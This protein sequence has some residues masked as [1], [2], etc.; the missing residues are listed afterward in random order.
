L[1]ARAG[2]KAESAITPPVAT[3]T[4]TPVSATSTVFGKVESIF[5]PTLGPRGAIHDSMATS[6][7]KSAMRAASSQ[8]GRQLI[9]GL[10]GGLSGGGRR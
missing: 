2:T 3:G 6:L 5:E 9:R 4:T 7:V 1:Q 8:M 10:L